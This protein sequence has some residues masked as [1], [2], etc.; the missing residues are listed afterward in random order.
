MPREIYIIANEVYA[1]WK[2]A[3][4]QATQWLSV[5]AR[6]YRIDQEHMRRPVSY[7]VEQFLEE[8]EDLWKGETADRIKQELRD[9]LKDAKNRKVEED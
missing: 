8:S 6:L 1:D 5:M 2:D 7:I 9:L 3:P 4:I